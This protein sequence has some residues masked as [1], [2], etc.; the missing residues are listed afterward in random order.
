MKGLEILLNPPDRL[1]EDEKGDQA[2]LFHQDL[3]LLQH[4]LRTAVDPGAVSAVICEE[5]ESTIPDERRHSILGVTL[6][7]HCK[8]K[9]ERLEKLYR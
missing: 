9:A 4:R 8:A 2:A 3:S 1:T 5:C 6:C 7:V